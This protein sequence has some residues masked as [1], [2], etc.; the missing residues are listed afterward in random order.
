MLITTFPSITATDSTT[1]YVDPPTT[2]ISV[3]D[4]GKTFTVN[5]TIAEVTDLCGWQ[6]KLYYNN[7]VLDCTN[8]TEGPFLATG[9]NTEFLKILDNAYNATHGKAYV[10]CT[11]VGMV[12]GVTGSGVLATI[13]FQIKAEGETPLNLDET[14]LLDS[15]LPDPNPID[16]NTV[17]GTVHVGIHSIAITHVIPSKTVVGR[18]CSANI[19]ATVENHG[20]YIET[21]NVTVYAN[22]TE[23]GTQTVLYLLTGSSTNIT[24]TWDTTGF[25]YGNYTIS[26]YAW[27]VAGETATGDNTFIDGKILVTI[28]GDA[29]GD[30]WVD[31]K[32]LLLYVVPAYNSQPGDSSWDANCDFNGDNWV[33]WKDLLLYLVPNYN[34]HWQ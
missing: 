26:A 5:I 23:I 1:I 21:F 3:V 10:A 31:W 29:N 11:L 17:D 4:I 13:K 20:D 33:D 19:N 2:T 16:H 34:Q 14:K 27:P 8:A 6:F 32:D 15:S 22:T 28:S 30:Q 24:F 9:G 18:S 12:P 7:T 25:S